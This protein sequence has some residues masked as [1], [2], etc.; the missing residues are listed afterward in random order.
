MG[1]GT[2]GTTMRI[3]RA[4]TIAFALALTLPAPADADE[5]TVPEQIVD[6]MNQ[7]FGRHPG[8]RANHAK[9]IVAEGRFAPN[10]AGAALS[11]AV[12]FQGGE[13]PMTVRFSDATG[14]PTIPD[15]DPN[16]NPH[17]M[18]IRF[19][20]PDGGE[21]DIV[22]NSLA[23]FPVATGEEFLAFLQA[24]AGSG[25]DT[26]KP[27]PLE[28]FLGSHPAALPALQS[29][30]TPTSFAR[31]TYHGVNAFVF[32]D[33]AGKRQPFRFRIEPVEGAEHLSAEDAAKRTPDYLMDELAPRLAQAPAQFRLSAQLA[34]PSD[35]I[36]D[37]TTPWP[38]DRKLIDLGT[39]TVTKVAADSEAQGKELLFLP[40]NL[41]DGIEPSDDPLID[42]RVQAYAVSFGRRS[43]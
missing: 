19:H 27:T 20:L 32:V 1:L 41:T 43:E 42:A 34:E 40:T 23:F 14:V 37:A 18:A 13:I 6:T 31:E 28:Q 33:A 30:A 24:V 25:P 39:I 15:G 38:A 5:V 10:A 17:G 26:A 29:A 12:L 35:P 8:V 36:D 7:L 16:A 11:T 2:G 3:C 4:A 22:A 9:G 21:M